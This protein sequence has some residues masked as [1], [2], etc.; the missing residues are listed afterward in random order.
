M[1]DALVV[2]AC[3]LLVMLPW[4]L[5][6]RANQGFVPEPMRGLYESY[7]SWMARGIKGGG[8]SVLSAYLRSNEQRDRR[9]VRDS[10]HAAP[11]I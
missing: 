5:W 7:S 10:R 3:A 1:R 9:H 2:G 11:F 6:V 8:L 4:Q